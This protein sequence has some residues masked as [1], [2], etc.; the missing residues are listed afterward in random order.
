MRVL[1]CFVFGLIVCGPAA[2][3]AAGS[4]PEVSGT[5]IGYPSAETALADLRSRPG[6]RIT[7]DGGVTNAFDAGTHQLW[8]FSRVRGASRLSAVKHEVVQEGDR[9][10][11]R[12]STL[13]SGTKP[14]CDVLVSTALRNLKA[15]FPGMR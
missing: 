15:R 8:T 7:Q 9:I 4:L 5:A 12:T 6:I 3:Q 13:C 14:A 1:A 11:I 2:T 10:L